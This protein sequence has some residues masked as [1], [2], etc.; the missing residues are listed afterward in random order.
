MTIQRHHVGK[1]LADM[2]VHG[3][4]IYLAGQVADDLNGDIAT[5]ARQVLARVDRLLAEAGSDKSR[6]LS[7]TIYL[8][9]M[10]DF[11]AMNAVWEAWV[12]P[13]QPPARA[14]VQA[15][16]AAAGYRIEIQ[17]IAAQ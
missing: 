13:G 17:V 3:G 14:T 15:K 1:R 2:V 6:I 5:Q 7:A 16:L 8:P 10:A 12:V 4:T 11:A 9:D